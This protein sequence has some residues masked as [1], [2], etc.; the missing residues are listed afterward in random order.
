MLLL[1]CIVSCPFVGCMLRLCRFVLGLPFGCCC[2]FFSVFFFVPV[3]LLFS[4]S[5]ALMLKCCC[6]AGVVF[7]YCVCVLVVRCVCV[8]S[9]FVLLFFFLD[10]CLLRAVFVVFCVS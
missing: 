4:C 9:P 8:G 1:M 2:C 3:E 5:C 6:V 10:V 7:L